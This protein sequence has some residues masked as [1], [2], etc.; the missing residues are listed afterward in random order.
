LISSG[1][2]FLLLR[3][4]SKVSQFP[5]G[6]STAATAATASTA[7]VV[8]GRGHEG[9]S[10]FL[11]RIVGMKSGESE[12]RERRRKKEENKKER[13]GFFLSFRK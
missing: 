12:E 11:Y 5:P 8:V 6:S 4:P 13:S 1:V 9:G 2:F 10:D 3:I 7:A